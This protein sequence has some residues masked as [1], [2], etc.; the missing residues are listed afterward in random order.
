MNCNPK[1]RFYIHAID[2]FEMAAIPYLCNGI[3]LIQCNLPR[4]LYEKFTRKLGLELNADKPEILSLHTDRV[5][6]YEIDHNKANFQ[7]T[8]MKEIKICGIWYCND[9][10]QEYKA[11]AS[12]VL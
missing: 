10:K 11:A 9:H 2:H 8:T 4:V 7:L 1:K 12:K 3:L 6:T 5:R